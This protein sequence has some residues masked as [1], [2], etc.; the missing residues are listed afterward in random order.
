M[1]GTPGPAGSCSE[2]VKAT[3]ATV[4]TMA[5]DRTGR[6][7]VRNVAAKRNRQYG[8]TRSR[9]IRDLATFWLVTSPGSI[10][11]VR[12][13]PPRMANESATQPAPRIRWRTHCNVVRAA[14]RTNSTRETLDRTCVQ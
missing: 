6:L 11:R 14:R 2:K 9:A 4:T 1:A 10:L 7:G 13:S 8:T 3:M 5:R 12:D